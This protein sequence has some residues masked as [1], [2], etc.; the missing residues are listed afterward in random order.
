M[1]AVAQC[2]HCVVNR[3]PVAAFQGNSFERNIWQGL[4][5]L[6]CLFVFQSLSP[7]S[8]LVLVHSDLQPSPS[9]PRA[10]ISFSNTLM[11]GP[12]AVCTLGGS[13]VSKA[14][15]SAV[16]LTPRIPQCV[17]YKMTKAHRILST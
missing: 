17:I 11:F 16:H 7:Q 1:A 9:D 10:G 8:H 4:E 2:N 13:A 6:E 12:Q 15:A 5:I 3:E 14:A